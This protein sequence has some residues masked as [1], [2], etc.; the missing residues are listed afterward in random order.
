LNRPLH[1]PQAATGAPLG[2]ALVAAVGV[3]LYASV[4]TAV[5]SMVNRGMEYQ[6]R[7]EFVA[8][9]DALYQVYVNLYPALKAQFKQ[10]AAV[11]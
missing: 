8:R 10:L 3:G 11:P 5:A 1:L 2:D 4:E 7:A 9:Y 6:P